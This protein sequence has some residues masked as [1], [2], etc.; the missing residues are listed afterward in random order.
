MFYMVRLF[1]PKI[2]V[3]AAYPLAQAYHESAAWKSP[4]FLRGHN[5]FGMKPATKRSSTATGTVLIGRMT[6]AAFRS[7]LDSIRDY[8]KRLDYYN[9]TTDAELLA[10]IKSV[11][12]TDPN[13][14]PKLEAVRLQLSPTIISPALVSIVSLCFTIAAF[15]GLY[16]GVNS[17]LS[18]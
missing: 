1:W 2:Q 18:A 14:M 5:M 7:P 3:S 6:Y 10:N 12:A 16:R 9:I 4:L 13:Y 11:Y 8:F 17:V 15:F